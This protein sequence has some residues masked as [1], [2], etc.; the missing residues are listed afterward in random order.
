M[1]I[2]V[3]DMI[4]KLKGILKKVNINK[5]ILISFEAL[6]SG[7]ACVQLFKFNTSNI[8]ALVLFVLFYGLFKRADEI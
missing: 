5:K 3:R 1:I 4:N 6:I 7:C 8:F 2:R